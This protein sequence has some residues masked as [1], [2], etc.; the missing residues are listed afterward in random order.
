MMLFCDDGNEAIKADEAAY[1]AQEKSDLV[2]GHI[3]MSGF[4]VQPI[5]DDSGAV[6]SSRML[7]C[8]MA[9]AGG[10]IPTFVQSAK[11]PKTALNAIKG[12]IQWGNKNKQR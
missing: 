6:V 2:L 10:N 4:W 1:S 8:A 5:K 7:Y 11:G 9:E 12:A 3:F